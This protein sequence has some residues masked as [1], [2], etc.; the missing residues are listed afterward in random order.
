MLAEPVKVPGEP[1][2]RAQV[3]ILAVAGLAVGLVVVCTEV[4][5]ALY[6]E[7]AGWVLM[8]AGFAVLYF[9]GQDKLKTLRTG[10]LLRTI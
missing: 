3:V 10:Y 4:H 2:P 7:A 5:T 8:A 1:E 9:L 6:T